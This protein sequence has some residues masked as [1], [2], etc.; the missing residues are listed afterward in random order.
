MNIYDFD[1][2]LYDGDSTVDFF[3]FCLKKHPSLVRFL[4]KQAW[5]FLLHGLKR[6]DRTELKEYFFSFLKGVDGD[7]LLE[8]FWQSHREKI[9][10]WYPDQHRSDDLVISASPEFLLEPICRELGMGGLIASQVNVHTGKFEGPNCKGQEKVRRLRENYGDV[11]VEKFYSD[12]M[13]DFPLAQ[14]ADKAFLVDK[15]KIKNWEMSGT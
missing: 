13:A 5:G 1:G 10:I 12:S 2:T 3:L 8:P 9:F 6:I 15:G 14:L 11:P 7:K 4:P